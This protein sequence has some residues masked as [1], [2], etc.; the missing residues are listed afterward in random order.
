[1]AAA[2]SPPAFE[3]ANSQFFT[4][5]SHTVHGARGDVVVDLQVTIGI[6]CGLHCAPMPDSSSIPIA[7]LT[8]EE[9]AEQVKQVAH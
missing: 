2:R 9:A 8:S 1:M 3:P 6:D 5:Q 4:A 7:P